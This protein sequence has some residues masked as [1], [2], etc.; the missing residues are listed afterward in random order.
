MLL[1]KQGDN[2]WTI[3]TLD[4]VEK[5]IVRNEGKKKNQTESPASSFLLVF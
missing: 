1:F 4:K 2:N 3:C 5:K